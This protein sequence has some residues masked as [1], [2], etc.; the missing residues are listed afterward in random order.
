[1]HRALRAVVVACLVSVAC[2]GGSSP[3][4]TPSPVPAPAPSPVPAPTPS[5][6]P[7]PAPAPPPTVPAQIDGWWTGRM[8]FTYQGQPNASFDTRVF[9][10]QSD[11]NVRG[12][13]IV[14]A[15]PDNR[16]SGDVSGVLDGLGSET[17]FRGT[18]TWRTEIGT[19]SGAC[20]GRSTFTGPSVSTQLQWTAPE[21]QFSNCSDSGIRDITWRLSPTA[22][23]Q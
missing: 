4:T 16:I 19:G 9:L 10:Q 23:P 5:P 15:P 18:V 1:M 3:S 2:G 7:V 12:D 11:R 14:T 17:T 21:I 8:V 22:A 13:W 20:S 6:A